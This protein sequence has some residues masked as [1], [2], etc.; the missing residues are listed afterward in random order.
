MADPI[1]VGGLIKVAGSLIDRLFPDKNARDE[2]KLKLLEMEMSG[3]LAKLAHEERLATGQM[4]VNKVEAAH[5]TTFV[6]G[7]R[8]SV[9]WVCS[10]GLAYQFILQPF[11][12]WYALAHDFAVPPDIDTNALL[13]LLFGMLGLG[14]FRTYEKVAGVSK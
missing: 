9:G 13:T 4:E 8:P 12:A 11:L 3:E 10:A 1:V 2:A 14:A 7:W 5:R 6:A